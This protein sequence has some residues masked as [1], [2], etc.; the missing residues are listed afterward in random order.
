MSPKADRF[1]RMAL[2]AGR[3]IAV[4]VDLEDSERGYLDRAVRPDLRGQGIGTDGLIPAI[5]H[6]SQNS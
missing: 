5:Y 2:D 3:A 6:S 1:P 4:Q